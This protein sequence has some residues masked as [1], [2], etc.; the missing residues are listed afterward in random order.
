MVPLTYSCGGNRHILVDGIAAFYLI[1]PCTGT[2][3]I[4]VPGH[5]SAAESSKRS[6]KDEVSI[7]RL[8]A[9]RRKGHWQELQSIGTEV[10]EG[11]RLRRERLVGRVETGQNN[12]DPRK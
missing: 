8:G 4:P 2:Q 3:F 1:Y 6:L 7:C 12:S 10:A 9:R 11:T 5:K